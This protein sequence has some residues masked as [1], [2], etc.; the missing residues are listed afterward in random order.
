MITISATF[1]VRPF[2][3]TSI[4][5]DMKNMDM[6]RLFRGSTKLLT[7]SFGRDEPTMIPIRKA[8][9]ATDSPILVAA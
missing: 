6:N 3:V 8:P 2:R 1:S 5:T 7:A 4:P 9:I